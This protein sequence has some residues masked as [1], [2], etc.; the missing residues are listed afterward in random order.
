MSMAVKQSSGPNTPAAVLTRGLWHENPV[1]VQ[2]LGLCSALAVTNAVANSLAMG[3][4]TTFVLVCSST[5]VS[6]MRRYIAHEVR[7]TTYVLIIATFLGVADLTLEA[8]VP[9]VHK[10]LG[11]YIALI[12]TNCIVLG[13]QEAFASRNTV[14]LSVLDA[15]GNGVGFTIA[16]LLMGIPREVLGNGTFLGM[17]VMP[18]SF[19]PWVV[20]MLPPGGFLMIG[21]LLLV[22]NWH[23]LRKIAREKGPVRAAP[24]PATPTRE[25]EGALV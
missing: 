4:A 2:T 22:V 9:E 21:V 23:D 20:M 5:I 24:A 15:L 7:I 18:A 10:S 16:L 17:H 8:I 13:R 12:V 19:D 14:G 3:L 6:L 1:L 11:A 25:P